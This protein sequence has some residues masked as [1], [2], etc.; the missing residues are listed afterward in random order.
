M[1][2]LIIGSLF[3]LLF[4]LKSPAQAAIAIV[5]ISSTTATSSATTLTSKITNTGSNLLVVGITNYSVSG[6]GR[7]ITK[8]SDDKGN[9][10]TEALNAFGTLNAVSVSSDIWYC[11]NPTS[12][13]SSMTVTFG[14]AAQTGWVKEMEVYEISGFT[15]VGFDTASYVTNGSGTGTDNS[16]TITTTGIGFILAINATEKGINQNPK[17]GNEFT[18]GG[19][20]WATTGNAFCSL[21]NSIAGSHTAQWGDTNPSTFC[22]S[23]AAFKEATSTGRTRRMF[24]IG[25]S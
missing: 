17:S 18:S 4:L 25:G 1:K 20:I 11:L 9:T 5:H 14:G 13:V 2:K 24:I 10:Y 22:S 19:G 6:N 15:T 12:G 23:I 3:S 16:A 7:T 21:V 8:V